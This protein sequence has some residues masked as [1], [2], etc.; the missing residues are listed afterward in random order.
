MTIT[1]TAA[2][3]VLGLALSTSAVAQ[4]LSGGGPS[5]WFHHEKKNPNAKKAHHAK[6]SHHSSK[7]NSHK[8]G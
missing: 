6:T 8:H 4:P 5:K 3:L 7:H 2:A 1:R